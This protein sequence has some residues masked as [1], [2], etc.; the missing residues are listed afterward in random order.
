MTDMTDLEDMQWPSNPLLPG[1]D[2][3]ILIAQCKQIA[4]IFDELLPAT[5]LNPADHRAGGINPYFNRTES[6]LYLEFYYGYPSKIWTPGGEWS[7]TGSTTTPGGVDREALV[8]PFM[9]R[10]TAFVY[11]PGHQ[12]RWGYHG[13]VYGILAIDGH[14]VELPGVVT[15]HPRLVDYLDVK[16]EWADLAQGWAQ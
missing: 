4:A 15:P 2:R 12:G 14:P 3:S 5:A 6:G 11:E 13:P 9:R 16:D 1:A 7:M 8:E 10:L